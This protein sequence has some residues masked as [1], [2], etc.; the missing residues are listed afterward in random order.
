MSDDF[1]PGTFKGEFQSRLG[2]A[3]WAY[4]NEQ[5]NL[6]RMETASYLGRPAVEPLS[7]GLLQRFGPEVREDRIK[8]LIGRMARQILERRGYRIDRQNVRM[9]NNMFTSGTRYREAA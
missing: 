1:D 9:K 4:L 7:P 2:Q 3:V 8:Q 6:V 5:D